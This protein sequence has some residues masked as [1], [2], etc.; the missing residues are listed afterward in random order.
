[1]G[2]DD[3]LR[4][5]TTSKTMTGNGAFS[6]NISSL[7]P[8]TIYHFRVKAVKCYGME[9]GDDITFIIGKTGDVSNDGHVNV[10]DMILIGQH[11]G[12]TGSPRWIPEDVK[13]DGVINVP[14]MITIVQH[15]TG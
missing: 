8:G 13:K 14:D 11:W 5:E 10:L 4:N 2:T 6:D 15:W 9:Y 1:M 7:T 12:D 3:G